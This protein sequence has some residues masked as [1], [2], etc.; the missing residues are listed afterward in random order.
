MYVYSFKTGRGGVITNIP[1]V[2]Y[3]KKKFLAHQES[4]PGPSQ[5]DCDVKKNSP[6]NVL[7]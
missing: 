4:N 7:K 6:N 2:V 3:L 1:T 5:S